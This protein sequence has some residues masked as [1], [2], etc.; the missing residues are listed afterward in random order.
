WIPISS[1]QLLPC[2]LLDEPARVQID[3]LSSHQK[4]ELRS[5]L[6]DDKRVI[7]RASALY[8]ADATGQVDL[9]RSPSLGGSYR[10]VE[11]MGLFRAMAPETPHSKLVIRDVLTPILVDIEVFSTEGQGAVLGRVTTDRALLGEGVLRTPVSG[12]QFRGTLFT[13]PGKVFLGSLKEIYIETK[14]TP[15]PCQIYRVDILHLEGCVWSLT[16]GKGY[17]ALQRGLNT[18]DREPI[19]C[20]LA[21]CIV[22]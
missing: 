16:A 17:R 13:P 22:T 19:K 20:R 15:V 3:G 21:V 2:C 18:L 8:E 9:C 1:C 10:G 5:K 11:P 4:F 12:E 14:K 6:R 7:F